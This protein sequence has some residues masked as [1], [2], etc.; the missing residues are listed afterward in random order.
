MQT[1][2]RLFVESAGDGNYPQVERLIQCGHD[3]N[4]LHPEMG[5]PAIHIATEYGQMRIA[6]LLIAAGA[7]VD[8][9]TQVGHTLCT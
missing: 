3:V 6:H 7:D 9:L 1:K 8:I 5:Y 2:D 4:E